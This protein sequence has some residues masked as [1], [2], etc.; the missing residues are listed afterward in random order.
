MSIRYA[1]VVKKPRVFESLCGV[2]VCDFKV[3][4]E[5]VRPLFE[6]RESEK[7][8][9]GGPSHL[10]TLESKVLCVLMYYRTYVSQTFLGYLFNLHNANICRCLKRME[11]LMAKK[12]CIKKDR[13]LTEE[14]VLALLA[15]VT[16]IPTQKPSKKQKEKYSGKKKRHTLKVEMGMSE[17]GR[18]VHLSKVYG[19]RTHDFKIRKQERPFCRHAV[20]LVDSGYQGLQKRESLV[21]LPF[22]G[23]KKKPLTP[24]Q[25]VPN[26]TL[27]SLRVPI[28]HKFAELKV[29]K[30]LS[31]R[32][33]N[34][35]KKLHLR[36][37]IIAGI[38]NLKHGF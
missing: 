24:E 16:E 25:K 11:P 31:D 14:K 28:E 7:K 26:K 36:L 6:E 29:F 15:D 38:V 32:Y 30:I 17:K 27:A 4:V 13:T 2:S 19:G 35:Q 8:R 20:K 22:K 12:I 9:F 37:N 34:F 18:I 23:S 21:W 5:K 33:R 3:L 1:E 10:D